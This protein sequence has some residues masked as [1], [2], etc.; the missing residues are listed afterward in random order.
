[1]QSL[2]VGL[3]LLLSLSAAAD[4]VPTTE[5]I[6]DTRNGQW[7]TLEEVADQ[8]TMDTFMVLGEQHVTSANQND[9]ESILHHAN[10]L[11][12]LKAV[13]E[14]SMAKG[15]WHTLGMEFLVYTKQ[16]VVDQYM[17][18][19]LTEDQFLQQVG[20]GGNPFGPYRKLMEQSAV[21]SGI[22]TLA[23]NIPPD[24][25]TAVAQNGKAS[26][27]QEQKDLCPPYW[28]LGGAEYYE[29]F[30][31]AMNGHVP[32]DKMK[33]YFWAQSLWDDTMAWQAVERKSPEGPMTVIVGEFHVEFNHGLPARLDYYG[34]YDVRSMIQVAVDQG[35]DFDQAVAPDSKY[36]ERADFIWVYTRN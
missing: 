15:M 22:G 27:T 8:M 35:A 13:N 14:K 3:C 9:P 23:L 10:Q 19:S 25:S 1:M 32:E 28:R 31:A 26:L 20:W 6:Y 12:W 29:R 16:P 30:Q 2:F 18:G 4:P 34:A 5:K 24:I 7:L 17:L 33:D 36:G 11:R 21:G